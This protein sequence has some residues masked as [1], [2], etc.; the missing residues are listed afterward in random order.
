VLAEAALGVPA[1]IVE[2]LVE[3]LPHGAPIGGLRPALAC[4]ARVAPAHC[5][6]NVQLL[7]A[8]AVVVLGIVARIGQRGIDPGQ[9]GGLPHRRGEVRRVLARPDA[10]HRADDQMR[11]GVDDGRQ[12]RPSPLPVTRPVRPPHTE[13]GTDVPRLEA[14][15]VHSR[16]RRGVDQAA[17]SRPLDG[18]GLNPEESPPASA[19]ARMRREAWASVE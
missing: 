8:E 15:R 12:L 18:G 2:R 9:C 19:S 11:V 5:P 17:C 6:P 16:H 10:G 1:L 7:T 13:G 4:M 14:G 3:V